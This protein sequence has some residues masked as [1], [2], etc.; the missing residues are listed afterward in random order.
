MGGAHT[1]LN[2]RQGEGFGWVQ[3]AHPEDRDLVQASWIRAQD[4]GEFAWDGRLYNCRRGLYEGSRMRASRQAINDLGISQWRAVS[5]GIDDLWT[6]Q[7][8]QA[9]ALAEIRRRTRNT[10]GIVRSIARRTAETS[11][12]VESYAMHFEGR[13]DAL[14]RVGSSRRR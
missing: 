5:I 11:E 8:E 3:A 9:A 6:T 2:W 13:F 7:V 4:R 10:L 14:A 12:G 1:G